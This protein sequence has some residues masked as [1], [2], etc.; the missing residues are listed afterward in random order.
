MRTAIV[1]TAGLLALAGC[2][3]PEEQR[4]ADQQTCAGYGFAPGTDA[5]AHCMMSTAQQRTA[6]NAA[7]AQQQAMD[8][9][10]RMLSIARNGQSQFPVCNAASP[11]AHIDVDNFAWFGDGCR[12]K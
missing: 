9:S 11:G 6:I 2:V 12:E 4:A 3:S 7:A 10:R 1:L 8:A 5:F